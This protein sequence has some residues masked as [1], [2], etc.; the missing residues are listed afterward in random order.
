MLT[1]DGKRHQVYIPVE[2]AQEVAR[3]VRQAKGV[4]KRRLR[5]DRHKA[6]RDH[7]RFQWAKA[8]LN[9]AYRRLR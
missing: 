7:E 9:T 1:Q 4:R 6:Q 8:L 3:A 2:Q 5:R